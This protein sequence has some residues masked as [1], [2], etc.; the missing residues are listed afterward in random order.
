MRT[1][2][3]IMTDNYGEETLESLAAYAA[4]LKNIKVKSGKQEYPEA[5][6]NDIL[7]SQ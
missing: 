4:D 5:V 7:F 3:M 1:K 6:M 2:R